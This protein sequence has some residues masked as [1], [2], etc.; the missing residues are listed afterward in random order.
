MNDA[1]VEAVGA[2]TL[3]LTIYFAALLVVGWWIRRR[4]MTGAGLGPAAG[5]WSIALA[6][7]LSSYLLQFA[8]FAL[9]PPLGAAAVTHVLLKLSSL[10]LFVIAARSGGAEAIE[11]W[12]GL[13]RIPHLPWLV[14]GPWC[15]L[16]AV[17]AWQGNLITLAIDPFRAM[18][19]TLAA[20]L[21]FEGVVWGG[22]AALAVVAEEALFRGA[23][24]ELLPPSWSGWRVVAV[25]SA[26]FGLIHGPTGAA[27]VAFAFGL[28]LGALRL[29]TKTLW[30]C[31][32][33]HLVWN[34]W[35]SRSWWFSDFGA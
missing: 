22:L 26:A 10:A 29:R 15:A 25:S 32:V 33:L 18:G 9:L 16:I 12:F 6:T 34:V 7:S 35:S 11:R 20:G 2:E 1:S 23:L 13:G 19:L 14:A 21:P 3:R 28:L 17:S 8:A 4:D 24:F 31:V 27:L 5:L 30:P